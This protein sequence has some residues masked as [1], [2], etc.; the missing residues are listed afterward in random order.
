MLVYLL[1]CLEIKQANR[2]VLLCP[3]ANPSKLRLHI[4]FYSLLFRSMLCREYVE[5]G[6]KRLIYN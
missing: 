2:R 1:F 6:R 5:G 4:A 3:W